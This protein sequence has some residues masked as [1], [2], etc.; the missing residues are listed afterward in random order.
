MNPGGVLIFHINDL[1][2]VIDDKTTESLQFPSLSFAHHR[3]IRVSSVF[4]PWQHL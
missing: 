4:R 3:L 2:R 1:L